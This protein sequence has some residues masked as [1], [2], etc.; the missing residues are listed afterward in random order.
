[1]AA[2]DCAI[3]QIRHGEALGESARNCVPSVKS[4][5]WRPQRCVACATVASRS[6]VTHRRARHFAPAVFVKLFTLILS[7]DA[8]YSQTTLIAGY[9]GYEAILALQWR[10]DWSLISQ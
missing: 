6:K 5:D 3:R 10:F 2:T 4:D 8:A 9:E 7:L 1:M